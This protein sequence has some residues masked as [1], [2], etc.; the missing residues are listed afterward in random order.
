MISIT[1]PTNNSNV[2]P[3]FSVSG[4]CDS[5]HTITVTV[6]GTNPLLSQQTQPQGRAG[7]WLVSFLDVPTGTYTI[8]AKCGNPSESAYVYNVRVSQ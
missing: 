7:N 1:D 5:I 6:N 2:F 3:S 4:L 8:E